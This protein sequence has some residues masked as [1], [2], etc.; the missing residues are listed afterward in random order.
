MK[1]ASIAVSP[2]TGLMTLTRMLCGASSAAIER[3]VVIAA[4]LLPLY[5]VRPGR[6]RTPAVDAIVM[7]A[8]LRFFRKCGT[9]CLRRQKQALHVD[10]VDPVE[11]GFGHVE[12]RLVA[13]RRTGIVDDDVEIAVCGERRGTMRAT[14]ASF[15]TSPAQNLACPP[16]FT[17][18][19]R[20][21]LAVRDVDVVDDDAS[22]LPRRSAWRC[23][24]RTRNPRR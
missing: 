3:D 13:M 10:P 20:D 1:S 23:L 8:P 14:S 11:L 6:G 15:A 19:A 21:A 4:P 5:Q 12:H 7:K 24:R 9:A 2:A 16:A 22:R 18:L 17:Y